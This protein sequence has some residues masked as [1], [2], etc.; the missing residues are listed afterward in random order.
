MEV[1]GKKPYINI[2]IKINKIMKI[3]L[4]NLVYKIF[5][6][7]DKLLK[8]EN[9]LSKSFDTYDLDTKINELDKSGKYFNIFN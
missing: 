2:L 1:N 3:K 8:I 9:H 6:K 7:Q 4:L 5:N